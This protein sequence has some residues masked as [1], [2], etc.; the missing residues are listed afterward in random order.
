MAV[1]VVVAVVVAAWAL[2]RRSRKPAPPPTPERPKR[3]VDATPMNGLESA[4]DQTTDRSGRNMREK[5]ESAT[6]IDDLR[7]PDDTGP[8]LGRALDQVEHQHADPTVEP[9]E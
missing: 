7:S 6:V 3:V 1:I 2:W 8:I 9:H 5:I 4:L